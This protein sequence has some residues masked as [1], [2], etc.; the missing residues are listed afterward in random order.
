MLLSHC[1]WDKILIMEKFY[2]DPDKLFH[3]AHVINPFNISNH[4]IPE[5]ESNECEICLGE[6]LSTV[7][8][9]LST[10]FY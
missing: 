7:R 8:M 4:S 5:S 2:N 6:L 1:K 9:H 3:D 10:K